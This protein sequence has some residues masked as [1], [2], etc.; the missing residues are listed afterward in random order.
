[1]AITEYL[2]YYKRNLWLAFPVI[3]SQIGQVSVHFIDNVMVGH[4]GTVE[5]AAAA[6]ANSIF[7]VGMYF[8]MGITFASL[9]I[10]LT[11][12]MIE[13]NNGALFY[14]LIAVASVICLIYVGIL[15][16]KKLEK[17]AI[18]VILSFALPF[19]LVGWCFSI[20]GNM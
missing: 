15:F 17:V 14:S 19:L 12:S 10:V 5:L 16:S 20:L 6:F 11:L 18:G 3:V 7:M 9:L 1:M 8:G 4:V 2:P 13:P